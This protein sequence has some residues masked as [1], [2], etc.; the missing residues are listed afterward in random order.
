MPDRDI[1]PTRNTLNHLDEAFERGL[2]R[3]LFEQLRNFLNCAILFA[4]GSYATTFPQ[5]ILSGILP[6][7]AIGSVIMAIA[8][9]LWLMNLYDA[10]RRLRSLSRFPAWLTG[11][12][13][14]LYALAAF[15][16]VEVVWHLRV[17][18]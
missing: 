2:H 10:V 11:I 14:I 12:T 17:R 5:A 1:A 3:A 7:R 18:G 13:A 8:A 15:R 16:I 4:A 6:A 9:A